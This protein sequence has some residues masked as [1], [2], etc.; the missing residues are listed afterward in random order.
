MASARGRQ[1]SVKKSK[2]TKGHGIVRR[3][4]LRDRYLAI[5]GD[6]SVIAAAGC[7]CLLLGPAMS[8]NLWRL[9][10][11]LTF[12]VLPWYICIFFSL[13][14]YSLLLH[15]LVHF[16]LNPKI[17]CSFWPVY[18]CTRGYG[19]CLVLFVCVNA[20]RRIKLLSLRHCVTLFFFFY[21]HSNVQ[22]RKI[23]VCVPLEAV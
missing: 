7:A 1:P 20:P 12:F 11:F 15:Q 4:V 14:Y 8:K 2:Y 13:H 19:L 21:S 18:A 3:K 16:A 23:W 17:S 9:L 6:T 10:S 5:L 22:K